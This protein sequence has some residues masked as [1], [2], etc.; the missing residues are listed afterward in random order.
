MS[1]EHICIIVFTKFFRFFSNHIGF[2]HGFRVEYK[3]FH[4]APQVTYSIGEC[5]G[6]FTT[7]KGILTSPT[8]P[9]K[10]PDNSDCIYIISQ[11][12]GAYINISF[13]SMDIDCKGSP[14]D[15]IEIRDGDSGN[16]A[17]M[18]IFCGDG[19]NIPPIMQTSQNRLR[20][21]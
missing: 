2:G 5:G 18:G 19:T 13:L 12:D 17:L 20:M 16:S 9:G 1:Y 8:Y 7:P 15:Y 6:N 3:T 14:S 21:R 11:P 10:Y 4:G